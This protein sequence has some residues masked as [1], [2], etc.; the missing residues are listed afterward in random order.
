MPGRAAVV[1]GNGS[2]ATPKANMVSATSRESTPS[3]SD[4][5]ISHTHARAMQR[6]AG[7][8]TRRAFRRVLRAVQTHISDPRKEG[9]SPLWRDHVLETFRGTGSG[10]IARS[11]AH[12][13]K[14][15]AAEEYAFLVNAVHH[16]KEMLFDYGHSLEKEREQ[17]KKATSTARYVGLD[18]PSA[19]S[20]DEL[21]EWDR[22]V[23]DRNRESEK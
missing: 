8:P 10:A 2:R 14:V 7:C 4:A 16:H 23:A 15:R 6:V 9:G 22:N 19:G 21:E 11:D 5:E 3:L 20:K 18:M 17:L 12:E 13:A 1:A